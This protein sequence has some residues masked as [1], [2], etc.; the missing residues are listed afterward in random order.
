[1]GEKARRPSRYVDSG[2][3]EAQ[4]VDDHASGRQPLAILLGREQD[5][6]IVAQAGSLTEA[7][8]TLAEPPVDVAVVD[9]GLPD[10]DGVDLVGDVRAANPTGAVLILTGETDRRHLARAV[11][12][13]ASGVLSKAAP[14]DEIVS[15]VRRL[16]AGEPLL[17]ARELLEL[18][19]IAGRER[20]QDR[21]AEAALRRLTTREHEVLQAVAEGLSDTE[22]AARLFISGKT[23]RS[24]MASILAKLGVESR[25]QALIFAIRQGVVDV[26]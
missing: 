24:H 10:R 3:L 11:E 15:A 22:I 18:L 14:L 12:A 20:E 8:A 25:P 4:L 17:S 1:L 9:L 21:S 7:R 19:R 16:A 2:A 5:L 23:V 13:G 6:T 26:R